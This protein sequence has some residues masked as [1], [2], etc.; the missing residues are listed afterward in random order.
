LL[1]KNLN[2]HAEH[3]FFAVLTEKTRGNFPTLSL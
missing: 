3:D 2:Q 1:T